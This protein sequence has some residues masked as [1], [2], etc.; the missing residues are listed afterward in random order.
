ML[1]LTPFSYLTL[2]VVI[3]KWNL[4]HKRAQN[5]GMLIKKPV[6]FLDLQHQYWCIGILMF[7]KTT[8]TSHTVFFQQQGIFQDERKPVW[9]KRLGGHCVEAWD[10]QPF[11]PGGWFQLCCLCDAGK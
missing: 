10:N 2:N 3:M 8:T 7:L 11:I 6:T 5:L 4:P 9:K 1:Q